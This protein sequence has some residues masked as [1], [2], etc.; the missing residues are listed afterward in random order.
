M[1]SMGLDKSGS[2]ELLAGLRTSVKNLDTVIKDLNYI[3]QSKKE[4]P[5]SIKESVDLRVLVE[6]IKQSISHL[7]KKEQMTFE[8]D[9]EIYK[10]YTVRGYLYSI[11]YNLILN[12]LK[13]RSL[14]HAPCLMIKTYQTGKLLNLIF[15]DNGKGIDMDKY[16]NQLFGLYKRF[17]TDVEG[18]GMGLFMVK[19]QIEDLG[20][21]VQVQSEPEKGTTFHIVLPINTQ[22]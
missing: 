21:S 17:D 8:Y 19:T 16:G 9:M 11:F 6:E 3:L 7:V 18:K 13:Y 15:K 2:P 20:G 14:N 22:G 5:D 10:T 1:Y 12:S 4:A